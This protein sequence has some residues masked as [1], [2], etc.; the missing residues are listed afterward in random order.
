ME[1]HQAYVVKIAKELNASQPCVSKWI[2]RDTDL[3]GLAKKGRK[4][5]QGSYSLEKQKKMS[6]LFRRLTSDLAK[7]R[8]TL[9]VISQIRDNIGVIFGKKSKRAG[10][11]ALDFYASQVLWF[12]EITVLQHNLGFLVGLRG[13]QVDR[14][15]V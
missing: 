3:K 7:T 13:L 8:L 11:K 2:N 1:T 5:D 4:I 9:V 6:E 10:G 14:P 15:L 12:A